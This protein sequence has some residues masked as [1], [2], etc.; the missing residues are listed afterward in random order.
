VV[1]LEVVRLLRLPGDARALVTS[2]TA[3]LLQA[4]GEGKRLDLPPDPDREPM[5]PHPG[6]RPMHRVVDPLA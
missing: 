1:R 5:R 2:E 6:S 4:M 3:E